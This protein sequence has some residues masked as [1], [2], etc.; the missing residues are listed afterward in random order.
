MRLDNAT[1][2][3]GMGAEVAG[4]NAE[5]GKKNGKAD[6]NAAANHDL[7]QGMNKVEQN[8]PALFAKIMTDG[9]NG[10]G[11]A[12]VKEAL[13]AEKEGNLTKD[14]AIDAVSGAQSLANQNGGG[15]INKGVRKEAETQLGGNYIHGGQTRAGHAILKFLEDTSPLAQMIK[16]IKSKTSD[17]T[18]KENVLQAGQGALQNGVGQAMSDMAN[19]DPLL[20]QQFAQDA[21]S[22]NGN[23][24]A[25]DVEVA[26]EESKALGGGFSNADGATL[27]SQIGP[28]GK[29]KVSE[30]DTK[31]FEAEFGQ[32]TIDRGSSQASKGWDKF[33]NGVGNFMGSLVSPVTDGVGAIDQF[34]KG[35][36]AQGLKDLGGAVMGAVSDAALVVAPEAAPEIE[37][38]EMAT[39]AGEAGAAGLKGAGDASKSLM[40]MLQDGASKGYDTLNYGMNVEG[41]A[42]N[43]N[44]D[45]GGRMSLI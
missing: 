30:Q 20:A 40:Q 12:L 8:D 7:E 42:E 25:Q 24:M 28:M 21:K 34:A 29:G 26:G 33:E 22:K 18:P 27:G 35:N 4:Q 14:Q 41:M 39:R 32:G 5:H 23:A 31:D 15:K 13:Q 9:Q 1:G 36:T 6:K 11:N 2:M 17:G 44:Q 3:G 16:G 19:L 38:A 45:G 37:G 10:N 43:P